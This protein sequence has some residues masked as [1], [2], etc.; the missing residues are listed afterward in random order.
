M[1]RGAGLPSGRAMMIAFTA[2]QLEPGGLAQDQHRIGPVA[3]HQP[4]GDLDRHFGERRQ[5]PP[6][7]LRIC[8]RCRTPTS[9][10]S[11]IGRPG[12]DSARRVARRDNRA[13]RRGRRLPWRPWRGRGSPPCTSGVA[14]ASSRRCTT[15]VAL[16]SNSRNIGAGMSGRSPTFSARMP[17]LFGALDQAEKPFSE[18]RAPRFSATRRAT[19]RSPR[20]TSTSVTASP[21]ARRPEIACRWAWL[22][23]WRRRRDRLPPAAARASAPARRRRYRRRWRACAAP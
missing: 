4:V 18:M 6:P 19:S 21:S 23:V 17:S 11:S 5:A 16:V 14:E 22:L 12:R 7:S 10:A 9:A 8:R 20:R 3:A 13:G 15:A 2:G 1:R